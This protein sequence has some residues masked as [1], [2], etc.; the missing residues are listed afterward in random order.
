MFKLVDRDK[1]GI[2]RHLP[3]LKTHYDVFVETYPIKKLIK[4][5]HNKTIE[6]R[7]AML[8]KNPELLPVIVKILE[9][10]DAIDRLNRLYTQG[11]IRVAHF[12]NDFKK[13]LILT[14]GYASLEGV[15]VSMA[16]PVLTDFLNDNSQFSIRWAAA[17]TLLNFDKDEQRISKAL[18]IL[19][20]SLRS[21]SMEGMREIVYALR[22]NAYKGKNIDHLLP[23]LIHIL[24]YPDYDIFTYDDYL[25]RDYRKHTIEDAAINGNLETLNIISERITEIVNSEWYRVSAEAN[26]V[27][28]VQLT[29]VYASIM[30]VVKERYKEAA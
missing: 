18:A 21:F 13:D 15:D 3:S 20:I 19:R 9:D 25:A 7:S 11:G 26:T 24:A 22:H 14:I 30:A 1:K 6:Q 8:I 27:Q 17:Y 12:S 4:K 2:W 29:Q 16:L 5:L 28:F 23:T 10:K